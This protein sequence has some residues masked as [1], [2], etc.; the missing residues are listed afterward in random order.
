[1]FVTGKRQTRN[2]GSTRYE[3]KNGKKTEYEKWQDLT[4]H[5]QWEAGAQRKLRKKENRNYN[6]RSSLNGSDEQDPVEDDYEPDDDEYEDNSQV[7]ELRPGTR[8]SSRT[9]KEKH[10]E[11][12]EE[13]GTTEESDFEPG[14]TSSS[15][16]RKRASG[17]KSQLKAIE[18]QA[19]QK[20]LDRNKHVSS[21]DTKKEDEYDNSSRKKRR[22][23]QDS[24]NESEVGELLSSP[25]K[26]DRKPEEQYPKAVKI[27]NNQN[28]EVVEA[29]DD[30]L[31]FCY[32][33]LSE[34]Y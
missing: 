3:G 14:T 2:S 29:D 5:A 27:E 24:E 23:I 34:A 1:M 17:E 7:K 13:K 20:A 32:K 15:K 10:N 18:E 26:G 6:E 11:Q 19:K 16:K 8:R 30:I 28:E 25:K 31:F 33:S 4:E 21:P 9:K 12:P 22:I